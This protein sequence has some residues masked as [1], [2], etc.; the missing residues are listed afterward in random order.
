MVLVYNPPL[1]TAVTVAGASSTT[2]SKARPHLQKS[3]LTGRWK[4]TEYEMHIISRSESV[5]NEELEW[6]GEEESK[7]FRMLVQ[8][9]I[10][11]K[12]C[13]IIVLLS[14]GGARLQLNPDNA[15]LEQGGVPTTSLHSPHMNLPSVFSLILEISDL[16]ELTSINHQA[17][18]FSKFYCEGV[19]LLS[20]LRKRKDTKD[21]NST[22][23]VEIRLIR[24][25]FSSKRH[26]FQ[27]GEGETWLVITSGFTAV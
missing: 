20:V 14:F 1:L 6:E 22:K 13:T 8:K 16:S 4:H 12:N 25:D 23:N 15:C 5:N 3:V 9:L 17:H 10:W 26:A 19:R 24:T 2:R 27:N 11:N 21:T 18:R 7:T